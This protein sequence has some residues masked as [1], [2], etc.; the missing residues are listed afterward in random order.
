MKIEHEIIKATR[1]KV[2]MEGDITEYAKNFLAIY[3][4]VKSDRDLLKV[5]NDYDNGVY[6]VCEKSV[7]DAAVKFLEQFGTIERI[8]DVEVVKSW[9]DYDFK[10]DIDVE[11]LEIEE[12]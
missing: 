12:A 8:E 5:Y 2:A 11:F 7:T 4:N 1:I 10:E 9:C 6:L 3:N